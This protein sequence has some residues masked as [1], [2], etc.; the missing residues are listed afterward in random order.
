MENLRDELFDWDVREDTIIGACI[1]PSL[2][3]SYL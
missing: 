2:I 3:P 1:I